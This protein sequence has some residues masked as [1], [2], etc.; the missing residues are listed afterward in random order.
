MMVIVVP[1]SGLEPNACRMKND[2]FVILQVV[3]T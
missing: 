1:A 3:T 2:Q